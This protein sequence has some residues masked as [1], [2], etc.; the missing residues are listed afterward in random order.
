MQR[1]Y[2]LLFGICFLALLGLGNAQAQDQSVCNWQLVGEQESLA[3]GNRV[4]V[5]V[6]RHGNMIETSYKHCGNMGCSDPAFQTTHT[7]TQPNSILTPGE[8][9]SFDVT[10]AWSLEGGAN[11]TSLTAG[12]NTSIMAGTSRIL[13]ERKKLSFPMSQMVR[14]PMQGVGWF[15]PV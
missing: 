8:T 13:A 6:D 11:C 5:A 1:L 2:K 9:L 12:V 7:W 15:P 14:F 4:G 3:G 10:A